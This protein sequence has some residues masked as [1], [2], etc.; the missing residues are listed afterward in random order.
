MWQHEWHTGTA[1]AVESM[2]QSIARRMPL[3]VVAEVGARRSGAFLVEY[4]IVEWS[5]RSDLL[6]SRQ[7]AFADE[8]CR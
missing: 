2:L 7:D 8:S 5:D 6:V 4:S 1:E 3:G